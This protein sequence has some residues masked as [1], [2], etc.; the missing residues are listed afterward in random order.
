MMKFVGCWRKKSIR[1]WTFAKEFVCLYV[2]EV[3]FVYMN[4]GCLNL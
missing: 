3:D 1:N 2:T 4:F